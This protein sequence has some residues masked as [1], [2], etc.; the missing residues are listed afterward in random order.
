MTKTEF[1]N[2]MLQSL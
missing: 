1:E 2:P